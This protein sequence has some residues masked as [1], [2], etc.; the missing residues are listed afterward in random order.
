[1][2][3]GVDGAYA[4]HQA[5]EELGGGVHGQEEGD[6]AGGLHA[7]PGMGVTETSACVTSWPSARSQAAGEARPKG[8]RPIS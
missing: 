2:G 3:A 5:E 6:Q 1:M 4:V 7:R 8:W